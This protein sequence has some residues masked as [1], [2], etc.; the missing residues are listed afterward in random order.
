MGGE[1]P[2]RMGGLAIQMGSLAIPMGSLAR[3]VPGRGT[4]LHYG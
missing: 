3:N 1:P 2:I 4:N